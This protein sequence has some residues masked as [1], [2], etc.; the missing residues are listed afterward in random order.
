[1]ESPTSHCLACGYDRTHLAAGAACPECGDFPAPDTRARCEVRFAHPLRRALQQATGQA[2]PKGWWLLLPGRERRL[3]ARLQ[4]VGGIAAS[5]LV[6]LVWFGLGG[7][8]LVV[9]DLQVAKTS[10]KVRDG[11]AAF[12]PA[13]VSL[14]A[15]VRAD[16]PW[17]GPLQ[18]TEPAQAFDVD[19]PLPP[20]WIELHH[21]GWSPYLAAQVSWLACSSALAFL[22]LRFLLLP[23]AIRLGGGA[24]EPSARAA[25]SVA[26]DASVGSAAIA[27]TLLVMA[28]GATCFVLVRV[29]PTG[30]G[31]IVAR[32]APTVVAFLL[33]A[34]P[35]LLIAN[36]IRS[37]R[38]RRVFPAPLLTA[39]MAVVTYLAA[40]FLALLLMGGTFTLATRLLTTL[41]LLPPSP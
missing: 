23:V 5:V 34:L 7:F 31:G 4:L 21:L 22:A 38:S 9:T 20:T 16:A 10:A 17:R 39:A 41:G 11:Y 25:A 2:A 35:P 32:I 8:L 27:F 29:L 33:A 30:A 14:P 1:M 12:T 28:A 24:R 13:I 26:A 3:H 36:E 6:L 19:P 37:D 15:I 40:A 18:R